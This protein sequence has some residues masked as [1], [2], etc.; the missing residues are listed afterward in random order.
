MD[1]LSSQASVKQTG[2]KA[3][4]R[5]TNNSTPIEVKSA[6]SPSKDANGGRAED[7]WTGS[8]GVRGWEFA[9]IMGHGQAH[10]HLV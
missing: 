3:T 7:H 6:Q 8:G 1:A 9:T 4:T 5:Y 10:G 2:I